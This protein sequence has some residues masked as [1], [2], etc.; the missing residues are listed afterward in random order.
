MTAT[1]EAPRLARVAAG[2]LADLVKSGLTP[3]TIQAAGVYSASGP[4]ASAASPCCRDD[5]QIRSLRELE[6]IL[7]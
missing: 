3:E 6:A 4:E 5:R 2:H 7:L 1:V